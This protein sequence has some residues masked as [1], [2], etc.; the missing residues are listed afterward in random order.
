MAASRPKKL[1]KKPLKMGFI[2]L[3]SL[4]KPKLLKLDL[5]KSKNIAFK[6]LAASRSK[7]QEKKPKKK[8]F[9]SFYPRKKSWLGLT[10][11]RKA[12]HPRCAQQCNNC[13][14]SVTP[15]ATA[16]ACGCE[17]YSELEE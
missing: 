5:E 8:P 6:K 14:F 16:R 1:E 17:R 3:S 11:H 2:F 12:L 15:Q 9:L 7:K 4:K 10:G 13:F